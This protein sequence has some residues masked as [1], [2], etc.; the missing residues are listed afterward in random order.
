MLPFEGGTQ[1][2]IDDLASQILDDH[3]AAPLEGITL[4]GGEPFAHAAGAS[5]LARRIRE[6]GSR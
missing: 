4:L 2:T 3:A 6:L 5:Q 1:T